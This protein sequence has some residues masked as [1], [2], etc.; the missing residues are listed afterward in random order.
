MKRNDDTAVKDAL[1]QLHKDHAAENDEF[2][3][4]MQET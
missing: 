2:D 3:A 4:T 1:D